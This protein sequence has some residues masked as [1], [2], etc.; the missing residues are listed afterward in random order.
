MV[1][2]GFIALFMLSAALIRFLIARYQ[3]IGRLD[4]PNERSMHTQAT[5]TGAGIVIVSLLVLV[6][7]SFYYYLPDLRI[8]ILVAILTLLGWIGWLDDKNNLSVRLRFIVFTIAALLLVIGIG[9]V[10]TIPWLGE[11][12]LIMPFWVAVLLTVLGFIWLINLYNFMDG[13]D[14]LAGMQTI[15]ASATFA[16]LFA[17]TDDLFSVA[18]TLICLSLIALTAGFMIWNWSPA[19][20]FLGDVGSLPIGGFFGVLSIIAVREFN[21]SVFTCILI[22]FVFFFDTF[23]TLIARAR[24]GEKLS[25]AHSSHLYQRLGKAG[26]PHYLVVIG[27]GLLMFYFSIVSVMSELSIN[28]PFVTGVLILI[29]VVSLL[30]SVQFLTKQSKEKK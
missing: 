24:R 5:P 4:N 12:D 27:Y 3:R 2:V 14:G 18:L 25:Q 16:Y 23:F 19:K 22:L 10:E 21:M 8:L 11:Q 7:G 26:V 9:P 6:V 1:I 28:T 20:I 30:I 17:Q 15:V 13:M 29:G